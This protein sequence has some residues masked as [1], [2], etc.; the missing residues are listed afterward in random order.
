MGGDVYVYLVYVRRL[1]S[2]YPVRL[3]SSSLILCRQERLGVFCG[4][5]VADCVMYECKEATA[6]S[7]CSVLSDSCVVFD[8]RCSLFTC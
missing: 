2:T 1:A 8:C 5:C 3:Y 7:V 6:L 4:V